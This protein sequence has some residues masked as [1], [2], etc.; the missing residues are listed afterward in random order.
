MY[1]LE[2]RF[3][4]IDN[5][6]ATYRCTLH[7]DT[8][9]SYTAPHH[10]AGATGFLIDWVQLLCSRKL[11]II[12]RCN[13]PPTWFAYYWQNIGPWSLCVSLP[14]LP[15]S[16]ISRSIAYSVYTVWPYRHLLLLYECRMIDR[17][18]VLYGTYSE[19][20]ARHRTRHSAWHSVIPHTSVIF[21]CVCCCS[22]CRAKATDDLWTGGRSEYLFTKCLQGAR[23][24]THYRRIGSS[25]GV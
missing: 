19:N 8:L 16:I 20:K 10:T 14:S 1:Q 4:R 21:V 2:T 11:Q 22:S 7:L 13:N 18:L 23:I 17:F 6:N 3:A 25:P 24:S 15:L 9:H 5:S 12:W